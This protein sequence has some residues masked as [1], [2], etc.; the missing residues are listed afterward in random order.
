[1]IDRDVDPGRTEPAEARGTRPR[2]I[3]RRLSKLAL[4]AALVQPASALLA[5]WAWLPDVLSHFQG[6]AFVATIAATLACALARRRVAIA[7]AALA[8]LQVGPLLRFDGANPVA[9]DPAGPRLRLLVANVQA[10]N[11]NFRLLRDLIRRER[12]DVVGLV[13]FSE[14]WQAAGLRDRSE[15]PHAIEVGLGTHGMALWFR[16]RP[17]AIAPPTVLV[18]DGNAV[19]RAEVDFAGSSRQLWLVHPPNPLHPQGQ[20]HG[21]E[22]LRA[23]TRLLAMSAGSKIVAGDMNRTDGSPRFGDF[24]GASGLRDSRLGFG[25]QASWPVWSPY[26]IAIDHGFLTPDLAVV[27]RRLGPNIGSDHFPLILDVAP[28]ASSATNA[29]TQGSQSSP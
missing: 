26:R 5:R 21:G 4:V 19:L 15:Y 7:L 12:P 23:L 13:E 6:P 16:R 8:A 1:M 28:A 10:D 25:R 18:P 20:A 27:D 2:R 14:A 17:R 11:G 29:A 3:L 22:E 9:A 24:L